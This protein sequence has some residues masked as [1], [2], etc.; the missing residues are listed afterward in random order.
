[1]REE[2]RSSFG[3]LVNWITRRGPSVIFLRIFAQIARMITGRPI[4]R[5]SQIHPQVYVG[6]QHRPRGWSVMVEDGFTAVVNMR[7]HFD[8]AA[9]DIQSERYL[10]LPTTDNTPPSIE[11]LRTGA[12]FIAA[13]V[14]RGGKVYIHCGVGVGRAPTMAAAYLVSTGMT[15]LQAWK[16]IKQQRPFIWPM[17]SQ[18]RQIERFAI[19]LA[20]DKSILSDESVSP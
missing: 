5:Y 7:K 8:D 6:G 19:E 10:H 3:M 17:P 14:E 2:K 11:D 16:H 13:E 4:Y 18:Y 15:P 12:Q 20:E 1:M 9:R